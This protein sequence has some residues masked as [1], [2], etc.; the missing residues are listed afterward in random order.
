MT[1]LIL[2]IVSLLMATSLQAQK[3]PVYLDESKPLEQRIDDA[4]GRMT[5]DEKIAVIHAQSKFSS[6]GVKRLG[7]PDLW[8]DDGPHGVRPDVLWD[9]WEQAG[10]TN[11]SC[12]AFPALTCL[13]ASGL[14]FLM[15]PQLGGFVAIGTVSHL[16][17]T[18]I[19]IVY[20][21]CLHP[22]Q[23][24]VKIVMTSAIIADINF[25]LSISTQVLMPVLSLNIS[26]LLQLTLLLIELAVVYVFRP[27]HS[28]R[29]PTA[30]W[31][32]MLLIALLLSSRVI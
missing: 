7:F 16:A 18:A 29:I 9:E 27:S 21:T 6:P 31:L 23:R 32:S 28:E 14:Y 11:D 30:Y 22:M 17:L 2:S 26:N 24:H 19:I 8:T 25:A 12:V 10:Q 15:A 5:L 4:L 1:K 3:L 20:A 13:A